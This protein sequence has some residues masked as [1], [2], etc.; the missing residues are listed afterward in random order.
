MLHT[1]YTICFQG[2]SRLFVILCNI[3]FT[4]YHE[5]LTLFRG[6]ILLSQAVL[7]VASD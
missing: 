7:P 5:L 6:K 2:C 1:A 4:S 3:Y